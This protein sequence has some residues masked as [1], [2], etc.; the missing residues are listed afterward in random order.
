M[1]TIFPMLRSSVYKITS[2][3]TIAYNCIAWAAGESDKCWWPDPFNQ[4][5][6]PSGILR[7]VTIKAFINAFELLGYSIC[8]DA[9]YETGYEKVAIYTKIDGMPTHAARQID[10]EK[11]TSKLGQC[12]DIEHDINALSGDQY[13]QPVIYMKRPKE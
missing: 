13:G 6:W 5:Y 8:E 9:S 4:Y 3:A 7:E 1:E 12:E 10:P 2:P 11:W